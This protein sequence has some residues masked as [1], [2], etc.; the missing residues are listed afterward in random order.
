MGKTGKYD[1]QTPLD[2]WQAASVHREPWVGA[3][4]LH[5]GNLELFTTGY[6]YGIGGPEDRVAFGPEDLKI[7]KMTFILSTGFS[8][9]SACRK[10]K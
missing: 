4:E 2:L 1:P 8:S 9:I 3:P 10:S 6:E 7:I 5:I